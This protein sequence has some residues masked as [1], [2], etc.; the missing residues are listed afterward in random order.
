MGLCLV[1]NILC[2]CLVFKYVFD[3]AMGPLHFKLLSFKVVK[4]VFGHPVCQH[5]SKFSVPWYW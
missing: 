2:K 4:G 5:S 1:S 3:F